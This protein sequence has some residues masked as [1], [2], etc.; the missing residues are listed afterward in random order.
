MRIEPEFFGHQPQQ[1]LFDF[2]HVF[3]RCNAGP[4]RDPEYVCIHGD[5]RMTEG[6]IEY[7]VGGFPADAR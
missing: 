7:N 3:P 6:G 4:V 1:S 5:G 2:G